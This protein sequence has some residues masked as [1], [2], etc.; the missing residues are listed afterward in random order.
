MSV[1]PIQPAQQAQIA[2]LEALAR[3]LQITTEIAHEALTPQF[4]HTANTLA[5]KA[6][7]AQSA[8]EAKDFADAALKCVQAIITLDPQRLA[9]GD[10]PDARK[11]SVP[12]RPETPSSGR[13][14]VRD[15]DHDGRIGE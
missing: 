13:P 7:M 11:A 6:A 3:P 4:A 1:I 14:A 10:T 2:A 8:A 12:D 15:S 9:G 5:G